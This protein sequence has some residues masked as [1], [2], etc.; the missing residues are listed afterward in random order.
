[1]VIL[2]SGYKVYCSACSWQR[3]VTPVNQ[4]LQVCLSGSTSN[5]SSSKLA[6]MPRQF[7]CT[8]VAIY[9]VL[10]LFGLELDAPPKSMAISS[11]ELYLLDSLTRSPDPLVVPLE[12]WTLGDALSEA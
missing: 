12:M 9:L 4:K 5:S 7:H 1:M 10:F 8:I 3:L 11:S 2:I 6:R